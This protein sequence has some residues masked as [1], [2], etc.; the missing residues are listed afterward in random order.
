MSVAYKFLGC[1][2]CVECGQECGTSIQ[3][4]DGHRF[5]ICALTIGIA[6]VISVFAI[7]P[8]FHDGFSGRFF[9]TL[10]NGV[11]A[12]LIA[13]LFLLWLARLAEAFQEVLSTLKWFWCTLVG[14][15][16]CTFICYLLGYMFYAS[17]Y[18]DKE[19]I[20]PVGY[21]LLFGIFIVVFMIVCCV[22]Y[23][24]HIVVEESRREQEQR[25][26]V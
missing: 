5:I 15:C 1:E 19:L 25:E 14:Y 21:G 24:N 13:T 26:Q 17:G 10:C 22:Y 11:L 8:M 7:P 20:W 12:G 6:V 16:I 18:I 4:S 2:S 3:R 23:R 9:G